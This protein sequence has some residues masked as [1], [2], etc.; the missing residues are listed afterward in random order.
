MVT[1]LFEPHTSIVFY[2]NLE[3]SVKEYTEWV[4]RGKNSKLLIN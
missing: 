1:Y 4:E 2:M 3:R